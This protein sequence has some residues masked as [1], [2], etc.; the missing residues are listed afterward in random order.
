MNIMK[1]R[2]VVL[3]IIETRITAPVS[4]LLIEPSKGITKPNIIINV[5]NTAM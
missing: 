1:A 2:T 4:D 5:S 3:S